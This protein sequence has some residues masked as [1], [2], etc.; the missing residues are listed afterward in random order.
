[1]SEHGVSITGTTVDEVQEREELNNAELL[2]G[3]RGETANA[4]VRSQDR[5]TRYAATNKLQRAM[6]VVYDYN[7]LSPYDARTWQGNRIGCL[8]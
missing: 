8:E 1:M 4:A 2:N 5:T 3:R 6:T 7:R